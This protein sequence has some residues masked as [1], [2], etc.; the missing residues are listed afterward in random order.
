M[1]LTQQ[2]PPGWH[3]GALRLLEDALFADHSS[4][5]SSPPIR[6]CY[7]VTGATSPMRLRIASR[8]I[9]GTATSAI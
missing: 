7:P 3:G 6:H 1:L 5:V 9:F 8:S 2:A 4:D